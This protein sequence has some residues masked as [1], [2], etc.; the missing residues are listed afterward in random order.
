MN[1]A[2][3]Q[4]FLYDIAGTFVAELPADTLTVTK[5]L[6]KI[7]TANITV[8]FAIFNGKMVANGTT[9]DAVLSSG[10]RVVEIK[11]NTTVVFKGIL[12]EANISYSDTGNTLN[13][14]FKSWLSYFAKRYTSEVFTSEDAGEI[15][16]GIINVAQLET[17]GSIGITKGTVTATKDRDRTFDRDEIANAIIKMS[18]DEVKDGFDFEIS[19]DKVFTVASRLGSDKPAI[20]FDKNS[21]LQSNIVYALGLNIITQSHQLGNGSGADQVQSTKTSTGT[22]TSKWYLQEKY[23][24]NTSISEVATLD[25]HADKEL[26]LNQDSSKTVNISVNSNIDPST[27]DIGDGVTL[28]LLDIISGLYRIKTKSYQVQQG[29]EVIGLEFY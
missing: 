3:W 28:D 24:N 16:W 19:N 12:N 8:D 13:L 11:R 21:I 2:T 15:A 5:Q 20:V 7:W 26:L 4:I 14:A 23:T 1:V 17:D 22:Y 6:N 27:Y 25:D 9:A 10:L 29:S 18:A